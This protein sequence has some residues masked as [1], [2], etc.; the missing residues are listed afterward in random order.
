[1]SM[2]KAHACSG[3]GS[4]PEQIVIVNHRHSNQVKTVSFG[5]SPSNL[6]PARKP[7]YSLR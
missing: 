7:H 1:V 5:R 6:L 4:L 2:R 3:V